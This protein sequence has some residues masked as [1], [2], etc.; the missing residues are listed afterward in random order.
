M[1]FYQLVVR[2]RTPDSL[3]GQAPMGE[4]VVIKSIFLL[5]I[6]ESVVTKRLPEKRF[7]ACDGGLVAPV[8]TSGKWMVGIAADVLRV[9]REEFI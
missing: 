1:A 3:G 7:R 6:L 8:R 5:T 2:D 9:G 4:T